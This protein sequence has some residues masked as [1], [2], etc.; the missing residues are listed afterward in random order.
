MLVSLMICLNVYLLALLWRR[1]EKKQQ[2]GT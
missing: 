2:S 1:P